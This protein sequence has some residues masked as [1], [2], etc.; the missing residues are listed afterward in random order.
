MLCIRWCSI[1]SE[2]TS[3]RVRKSMEK[4][5]KLQLLKQLIMNPVKDHDTDEAQRLLRSER[6]RDT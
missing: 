2:H 4:R 1:L 6:R 3:V 5:A